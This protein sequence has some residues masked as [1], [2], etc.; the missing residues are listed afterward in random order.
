M[1][2]YTYD[3]MGNMLTLTDPDGNT[4]TW[5]YDHLGR[6]TSQQETVALGLNSDGTPQTTL[7]TSYYSYDP[8]GDL[9]TAIDDCEMVG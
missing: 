9:L 2:S 6:V 4:T 3:A 5:T 7:A 8:D 1:T